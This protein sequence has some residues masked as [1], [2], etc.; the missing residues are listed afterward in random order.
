MVLFFAM[1]KLQG[2]DVEGVVLAEA[3]E[4]KTV[5]HGMAHAS[6]GIEHD[7]GRLRRRAAPSN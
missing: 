5:V 2:R 6:P 3:V 4:L 7:G 1:L